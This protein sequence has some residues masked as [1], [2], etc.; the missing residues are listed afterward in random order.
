[1]RLGRSDE[2]VLA[3]QVALGAV[4]H[5]ARSKAVVVGLRDRSI[6]RAP[7][8]LAVGTGLVN[9]ELVLGRPARVIP[10]TDH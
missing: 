2:A 5:E 7:P 6:D 4:V 8:D 3:V 9:D 10:G 1:M